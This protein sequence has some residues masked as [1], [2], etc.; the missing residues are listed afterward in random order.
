MDLLFSKSFLPLHRPRSSLDDVFDRRR[1][2]KLCERS[3]LRQLVHALRLHSLGSRTLLLGI[4][5]LRPDQKKALCFLF[6]NIFGLPIRNYT[7][8]I[9]LKTLCSNFNYF[10]FLAQQIRLN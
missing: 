7:N 6:E 3:D 4:L 1:K 9:L 10:D 2:W 8:S 5:D